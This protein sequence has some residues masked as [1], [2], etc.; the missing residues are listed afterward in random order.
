[1]HTAG[2]VTSNKIQLQTFVYGQHIN[3]VDR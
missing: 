3:P 2:D 1:M